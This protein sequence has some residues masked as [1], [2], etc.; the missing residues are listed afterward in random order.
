MPWLRPQPALGVPPAAAGTMAG[1]VVVAAGIVLLGAGIVPPLLVAA[2]CGCIKPVGAD[3]ST[4]PLL[5]A[6]GCPG[7]ALVPLPVGAGAL[8]PGEA[9]NGGGALPPPSSSEEQLSATSND[10][11][12]KVA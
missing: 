7:A 12:A 8:P 5:T 2:G 4:L 9:W 1:G 6:P 3:V 10:S 11:E